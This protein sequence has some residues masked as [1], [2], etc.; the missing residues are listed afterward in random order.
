MKR[1]LGTPAVSKSLSSGINDKNGT[2]GRPGGGLT[3]GE[4]FSH[5]GPNETVCPRVAE[6]DCNPVSGSLWGDPDLKVGQPHIAG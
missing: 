2:L 1:T 5:L 4:K 6:G 3:R